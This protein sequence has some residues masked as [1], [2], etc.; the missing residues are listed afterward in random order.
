MNVHLGCSASGTPF[1]SAYVEPRENETVRPFHKLARFY[2]LKSF[3]GT[4]GVEGAVNTNTSGADL[5][6]AYR[7]KDGD[8]RTLGI[9]AVST[10]S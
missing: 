7:A 4:I 9:I 8:D 3:L 5:R 2:P 10:S 1:R 6:L